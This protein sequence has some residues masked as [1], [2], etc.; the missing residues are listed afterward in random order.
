MA[1]APITATSAVALA[2]NDMAETTANR[3]IRTAALAQQFGVTRRW[4][5]SQVEEHG[6]PAFKLERTLLFDL[7]AVE[8]WLEAHRVGDWPEP[9]ADPGSTAGISTTLQ[10]SQSG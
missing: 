7:D 3:P 9:C 5:Y 8:R 2:N 10:E 4:V 1:I 6:L